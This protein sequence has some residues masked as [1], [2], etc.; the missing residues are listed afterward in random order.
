[1]KVVVL[2][3]TGMLGNAVLRTMA[4]SDAVDVVGTVRSEQSKALFAPRLAER[5]EILGDV[6]EYERVAEHLARLRPDVIINC[7]SP[8]RRSLG[9]G[10]ALAIIPVCALLPHRLAAA[11][12][13]MGARLVHVSTDGV[14]SGR[15]GGYTEMD[16][17][18]A[19][20]VYGIA[21]H[22]GEVD[23][24]HVVNLRTSMIGHELTGST[25]LLEWFL[26][27]N[28][29]CKCFRRAVFSGLPTVVLAQVVRDFVLPHPELSGVYHVASQAITKCELLRLIA[30][31]YG[32]QIEIL[33]DDGVAIDRSLDAGRFRAATGYAAPDWPAL[34]RTMH[35]LR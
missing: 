17:C 26:S 6:M 7:I 19:T 16:T 4:E 21:K 33:E 27:Q 13:D 2:G 18:D 29:R 32:K 23:A 24:P 34:V 15:K 25:G 1:M 31:T 28:G 35:A 22:L 30:R 8:D 10:D 20:D 12:A 9:K 14:F 5:L 3:A 11:C